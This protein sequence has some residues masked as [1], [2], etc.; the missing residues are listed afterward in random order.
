VW[1]AGDQPQLVVDQRLAS[2]RRAE[3]DQR[4]RQVL[5]AG[6]PVT[7]TTPPVP[8]IPP[9][10]QSPAYPAKPIP[11]INRRHP[12]ACGSQRRAWKIV[13]VLGLDP[14]GH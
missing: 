14:R 12:T 10:N 3:L 5:L 7:L 6:T 4:E 2:R 11:V 13:E 1:V 8:A 9:A